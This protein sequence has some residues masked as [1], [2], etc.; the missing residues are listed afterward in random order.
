MLVSR[1]DYHL[2]EDLIAQFPAT[3]RIGSRMMVLDR[4]TGRCEIRTFANFTS[5]LEP[6][7][8]LVLN[9]TKVIPARL[10][11]RKA[12]TGGRVEMML[13]DELAAGRWNA[14]LRPAKRVK[15][16]TRIDIAGT[17]GA[18]V[19]VIRKLDDGI[20][21]LIFS[22][23][24][25]YDLLDRHGSMPLPPYI[26]RDPETLDR[27]RYQTI[28]ARAPG[29]VAAPTAGLHIDEAVLRSIRDMQ[30]RIAPV[31]LHVGL[32]TFKPV[33]A[34]R[35]EDHRMHGERYHLPESSAELINRTK[36]E[37]GAVIAVGTTSVRVLETC[38]DG[39]GMVRAGLGTTDIFL[40]PP[41]TA[42]IADGLLTNFHLPKSTLLMLV[43]TFARCDDVLAAYE[44]AVSEKFR[45]YS[46]GDCMLLK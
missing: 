3:D 36:S 10:H 20:C 12:S 44:L 45:F 42:G 46:Y 43:C 24:D 34:L 1:F 4:Q 30:V 16:G 6:G 32:G 25:V 41:H 31:T 17:P 26:K 18:S 14:L 9:D 8:C 13:I 29:A 39:T 15:I 40:H 2:P 11:G 22:N 28:Y 23:D 33:S 7:D 5:F 21:E 35:I 37:G 19:E 38:S 27:N